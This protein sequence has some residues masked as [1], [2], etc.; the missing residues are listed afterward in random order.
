MQKII[1]EAEVL[2]SRLK[3]RHFITAFFILFLAF[4]MLWSASRIKEVT[5]DIDGEKTTKITALADPYR[6]LEEMEVEIEPEDRV[7]I[8][9]FG[10]GG[11]FGELGKN[12]A[13]IRIQRASIS[14]Q[15]NLV[16]I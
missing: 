6:V 1:S 14:E 3:P 2:V 15:R 12:K 10:K 7:T 8:T 4:V 5:V 16:H 11:F 13:E 9:G